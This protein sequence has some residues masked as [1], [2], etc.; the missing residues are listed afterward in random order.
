MAR[1]T[2]WRETTDDQSYGENQDQ[3]AEATRS[4]IAQSDGPMTPQ[5][6]Y[7]YTGCPKPYSQYPNDPNLVATFPRV[8]TTKNGRLHH[9]TVPYSSLIVDGEADERQRDPNPLNRPPKISFSGTFEQVPCLEDREGKPVENTAG[10]PLPGAVMFQPV[11]KIVVKRNFP[12]IPSWFNDYVNADNKGRVAI[13]SDALKVDGIRFKEETLM[14]ESWDFADYEFEN[15][16]KYRP[17]TF[18]IA[19]NTNTWHLPLLNVGYREKTL[20]ME[21]S[22]PDVPESIRNLPGIKFPPGPGVQRV[23]MPDGSPTDEPVFLIKEGKFK[24]RAYRKNFTTHPFGPVATGEDIPERV[25]KPLEFKIYPKLPYRK[26]L[27]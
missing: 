2:S 3:V 19:A 22:N 15:G 23:I 4:F 13:N 6:I 14:L 12:E 27:V 11:G 24:G 10:D 5:L 21:R 9:I 1:I 25:K 20:E 8:K 16:V 18:V 26:F 7:A 17:S